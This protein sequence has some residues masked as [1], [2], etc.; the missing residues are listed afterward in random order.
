MIELKGVTKRFN[1]RLVLDELDFRVARGERTVILGVSGIGK[2]TILKLIAGLIKPEAGQ[3][4]FEGQDLVPL[5]E[6]KL[7]QVRKRIAMVFQQ[8]ALFDSLTVGENVGFRLIEE[9]RPY[10]E[11]E[12]IVREKLRSVGLE[13]VLNDYPAALSGGMRRRL[14]IARALVSEPEL[15][16]F[17]EPTA[18]L[19]PISTYQFD[20]LIVRIA[21]EQRTTVLVVTHSIQSAVRLGRR[22]CVLHGGKLVF[23]GT[24]EEI[25][26][27]D[28]PVVQ[29]FIKPTEASL[30]VEAEGTG[31]EH[32]PEI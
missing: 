6:E 29:E 18:G 9:G 22:L 15:L 14:A 10:P 23:D 4:L 20:R 12:P 16:M 5:S 25:Y 8:G 24:P 2:T 11:V 32:A 31:I 21:R 17:D 30:E 27:S 26:R 13:D 7:T 19:D 3:V 1:H 28:E